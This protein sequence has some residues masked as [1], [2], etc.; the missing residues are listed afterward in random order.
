[1]AN[2]DS[3]PARRITGAAHI[4]WSAN[5]NAVDA[6]AD[7]EGGVHSEVRVLLVH[8]RASGAIHN[9]GADVVRASLNRKAEITGVSQINF[10]PI[11]RDI[12][13]RGAKPAADGE[14][15]IGVDGKCVLDQ[16]AAA[17]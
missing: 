7:K 16:H 15:I 6:P 9:C 12:D 11:D 10:R 4:K 13:V 1:M 14:L 8:T 17:S 5:D 3:T 2:Q